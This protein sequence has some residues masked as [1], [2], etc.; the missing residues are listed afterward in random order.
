MVSK[1]SCGELADLAELLPKG[2]LR[3]WCDQSGSGPRSQ[4]VYADS[5]ML[6]R[7]VQA[8]SSPKTGESKKESKKWKASKT[9]KDKPGTSL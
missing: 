5:E 6:S 9:L 4:I 2:D 7:C 3:E 8:V 1:I